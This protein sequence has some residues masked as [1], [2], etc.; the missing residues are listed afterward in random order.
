MR[1]RIEIL[2]GFQTKGSLVRTLYRIRVSNFKLEV[3]Q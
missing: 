1:T 2:E 3:A